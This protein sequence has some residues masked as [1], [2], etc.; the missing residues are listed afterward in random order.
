VIYGQ[1][2]I[3]FVLHPLTCSLSTDRILVVLK[4]RFGFCIFQDPLESKFK[5]QKEA[6]SFMKVGRRKKTCLNAKAQTTVYKG[7]DCHAGQ[8]DG[9]VSQRLWKKLFKNDITILFYTV[10][11]I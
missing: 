5:I 1:S 6:M 3:L 8:F 7:L 10:H 11:D 4:L 2:P 9:K